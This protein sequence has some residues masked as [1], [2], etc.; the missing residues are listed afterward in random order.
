MPSEHGH[1]REWD[2][3]P[4]ALILFS[5]CLERWRCCDLAGLFCFGWGIVDWNFGAFR[6]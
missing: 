5:V 3:T 4:V 6:D 2:H 1:R